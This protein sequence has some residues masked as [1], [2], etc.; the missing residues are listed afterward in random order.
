MRVAF[1]RSVPQWKTK[2]QKTLSGPVRRVFP[3][4]RG[5]RE[6]Y[7]GNGCSHFSDRAE[8]LDLEKTILR[9]AFLLRK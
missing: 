3:A 5:N 2:L 4:S 9:D 8:I 7:Q 1:Q 6:N